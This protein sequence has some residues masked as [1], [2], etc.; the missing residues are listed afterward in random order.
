MFKVLTL[1]VLIHLIPSCHSTVTFTQANYTF[2]V[3]ENNAL[4]TVLGNLVA[5]SSDG[6]AVSYF[7]V[8]GNLND[9]FVLDQNNG[10]L[11]TNSSLN[12]EVTTEHRLLVEG[13]AGSMVGTAFVIVY[14]SY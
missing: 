5:T 12:H 10:T 4:K 6:Q 1:F 3:F 7:I 9:R 13:R 11:R 14:V 8:A 2:N